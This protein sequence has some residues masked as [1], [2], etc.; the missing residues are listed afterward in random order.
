MQY[1]LS[2][3]ILTKNEA[4]QVRNCLESV[5]WA[6]EIIIIDDMSTDETLAICREYTDKIF[7]KQLVNF[8]EQREYGISKASGE[9]ILF[10][11]AD[12]QLSLQLQEEIKRTLTAGPGYNGFMLPR[13]S[14]YLG[15]WIVYCGWRAPIVLLFRKD[16]A[17]LDGRLVHEK[18]LVNG[19]VGVLKNIIRHHAYADLS[20]HIIKLDFYTRLEAEELWR[21]GKRLK[22]A[23]FILYLFAKPL[24]AFVRKYFIYK[25]YKE[26]VRGFLI[27][28]MTA[29]VVLLSYAKLWEK[30]KNEGMH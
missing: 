10:L 7:Y 18:I 14:S 27:S 13:I 3:V 23:D 20:E 1:K 28:V 8:S 30:Q 6:D 11:D 25:G 24:F 29:F 5:K 26:G 21:Q 16:K 12:D 17:R 2:A 4:T 15:K 22:G 19:K 9:W